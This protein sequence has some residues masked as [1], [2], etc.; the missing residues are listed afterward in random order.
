MMVLSYLLERFEITALDA[1]VRRHEPEDFVV[2]FRRQADRDRVLAAPRTAAPLPLVWRP[3]RRTSMANADTFRFKV[4]V[5]L[6]HVPLHVRTAMVAQAILGPCCANVVVVQLRDIPDDDDREMF[7]TAWCLHPRLIRSEEVIFIPEPPLPDAVEAKR[8]QLPGLR[9]TIPIR[10]VAFQHGGPPGAL[11][12]G[13]GDGAGGDGG[14]D[15]GPPRGPTPDYNPTPRRDDDSDGSADSNYSRC[16]PG[17]DFRCCA[18]G[19][20]LPTAMEDSVRVGAVLCPLPLVSSGVAVTRKGN[21]KDALAAQEHAP[22]AQVTPGDADIVTTVRI[23]LPPSPSMSVKR[24]ME[25]SRPGVVGGFINIAPILLQGG[26]S[27]QLPL[28]ETPPDWWS[29]CID[30]ELAGPSGPSSTIDDTLSGAHELSNTSRDWWALMIDNEFTGQV[31][32]LQAQ[33]Q[34]LLNPTSSVT[35]AARVHSVSLSAGPEGWSSVRRQS[36]RLRGTAAPPNTTTLS[37]AMESQE[38]EG[39]G[40][41]LTGDTVVPETPRPSSA[42]NTALQVNTTDD[43]IQPTPATPTLE[44]RLCIPLQTP[45]VRSRPRLR[46]SRTP[47]NSQSLRRSV[48]VAAAPRE[49]DSTKQ[50]QMVLMRKLGV[51]PSSPAVDSEA[52]R[53]YIGAFRQPLTDFGHQA[54]QTLLGE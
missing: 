43:I 13:G 52:V 12:G 3:W 22:E 44:S 26:Q 25:P 39:R 27:V 36:R 30:V 28:A 45:L 7:V 38:A 4:L 10:I 50:A 2:R 40:E 53:K 18:V 5:A 37:T 32:N 21:C 6:R 9:Y 29:Q 49:A 19:P 31:A 34:L 15:L 47:V 46:R 48:R 51:A 20:T 1:D 33:E 54:L 24:G 8:S 23:P 11:G 17:I 42:E 35:P 16:H 14:D 41:L